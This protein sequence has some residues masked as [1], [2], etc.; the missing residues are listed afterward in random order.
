M[1]VCP[2]CRT[3]NAATASFCESCGASLAAE[4]EADDKIEAMLL[5][6][7]RKGVWA[8]G[9]VA[10]VQMIATLVIDAGNPILWTITGLFAVLAVWA[11]RAPLIASGLGLGIFAVL[12]ILEAFVDPSSIYKGILLKVVVISL[13]V[14][15][16]KNGLAHRNFRRERGQA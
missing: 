1:L 3:Q 4:R 14:G 13:L 9:V 7:A 5:A 8:L 15:A 6:Q 2:K 12:H 11:L 10:V 16:I